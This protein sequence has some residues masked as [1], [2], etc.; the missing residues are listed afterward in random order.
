[1]SD[2][3]V[4]DE[5]RFT[6]RV[7]AIDDRD[8]NAHVQFLDAA[9]PA[10]SYWFARST[11]EAAERLPRKLVVGDRVHYGVNWRGEIKYID[12]EGWAAVRWIDGDCGA[13]PLS[14]LRLA[15]PKTGERA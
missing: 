1:M 2:I 11:I 8:R 15:D 13:Y 6:G 4:G 3:R 5:F 9:G 7:I 12:P 14:E 10:T